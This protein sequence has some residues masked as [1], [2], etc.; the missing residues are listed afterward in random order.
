VTEQ[1]PEELDDQQ[2]E[3]IVQQ[4]AEILAAALA[5]EV[6]LKLIRKLLAPLRIGVTAIGRAWKNLMQTWFD[7]PPSEGWAGDKALQD[8]WKF[9]AWFL[10]NSARR[11]QAGLAAGV[12]LADL[13]AREKRYAQAHADMQRKRVMAA[14]DADAAAEASM[15]NVGRRVFMWWTMLDERVS[16]DCKRLHGRIYPI[17][18]PPGGVYPGGKHPYCRCKP[19]AVPAVMMTRARRVSL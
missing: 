9:R 13:L 1:P 12:P 18:S 17:G 11:L 19:R 2:Q 14:R 4:V 5:A 6:A 15:I 16:P 3:Q 7:P 10:F 8:A